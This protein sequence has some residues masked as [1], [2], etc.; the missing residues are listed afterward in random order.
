MIIYYLY[1]KT[2]NI[3]GLK[4]LG[5]TTKQDPL[6]YK[7]SG[8]DWVEH[9]KRYGVDIHTDIIMAC[10]SKKELNF[11]GRYYST[12][13]KVTTS[14]DDYGNRIWA[15]CIPETGGGS[16]EHN[17]GR[18]RTEK[19]KAYIRQNT[20]RRYGKDHPGYDDVE[21]EWQHEKTGEII[22]LTRQDFIKK[23]NVSAGNVCEHINGNKRVVSG[24]QVMGGKNH[25]PR[26]KRNQFGNKSPRYDHTVY[27]WQNNKTGVIEYLTRHDLITKYKL[28]A[29]SICYVVAGKR[30]NHNGWAIIR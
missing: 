9:L 30:A 16:G 28:H 24:W 6:S 5:Q 1:I 27:C 23:F 4:Y 11:Y 18:K 12:L 26:I 21:Y 17:K 13:Y 2:H 25:K 3:T 15:N 19:Q 8:K 22:K 20:P 14:V 7:G 29:G 10:I